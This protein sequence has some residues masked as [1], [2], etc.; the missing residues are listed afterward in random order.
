MKVTLLGGSGFIGRH[1]TNHLRRRGD[2]VVTGSL[3]EGTAAAAAE[4][5]AGSDAVINLAGA[6]VAKRW[7]RAH[8][9]EIRSSRVDR[10]RELIAALATLPEE[11][12][13]KIYV[14]SSAIGYYG[15]SETATFTER[16][17]PGSGFLAEVC[18][19]LER[20]AERVQSLGMRL[21]ILRIGIVLGADGGTL[22][23]LLP[24]YR[25]GLGGPIASG[26]QWTSWIHIADQVGLF[27]AALDGVSGVLNGTAPTPVS[28]AVFAKALGRALGRPAVLPTPAFAIRMAFGEGAM[29]VTEGQRVLPQR[30]Q[31]LGYVFEY[32][33][34]EEALRS[35]LEGTR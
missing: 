9:A 20:E 17:G 19:A 22:R 6:A 3:R 1:L 11:T 16:D 7:T 24:L 8:M 12:R 2:T 21:A 29:I 4:L 25:L 10:T 27:L 30:T 23:A 18:V 34:L 15:T 28:N 14:V 31:E 33:T 32:P 35:A 5:C 26:R 13:P